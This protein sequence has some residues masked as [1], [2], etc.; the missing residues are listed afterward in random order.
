MR[1][2]EETCHRP[3]WPVAWAGVDCMFGGK[4]ED[5]LMMIAPSD[6]GPH[7]FVSEDCIIVIDSA[8]SDSVKCSVTDKVVVESTMALCIQV[9]EGSLFCVFV[10]LILFLSRR[11]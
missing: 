7:C 5:L 10:F 8:C 11:L 2:G 1:R 3:C 9:I 6:E 4:V